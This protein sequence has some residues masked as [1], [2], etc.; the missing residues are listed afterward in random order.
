MPFLTLKSPAVTL[1]TYLTLL[2][3]AVVSPPV[4]G[5]V[6]LLKTGGRVEG[7]LLNPKQKPRTEF[8]LKLKSG[9]LLTLKAAQVAQVVSSS[10]NEKRYLELLKKMPD[11]AEGNFKMAEFCRQLEL[12][13]QRKF[14]LK[15]VV[16]LDPTHE[17]AH[18][19]LGHV[20]LEGEWGKPAE[21]MQKRGYV[22]YKNR[23]RLPQDVD[24]IKQRYNDDQAVKK[25]NRE[26]KL[27]RSWI[28]KRRDVDARKNFAS[29]ED[30]LAAPGVIE[31]LMQ[32]TDLRLQ[33]A[34]IELLGRLRTTDALKALINLALESNREETRQLCLDQ[35]VEHGRELAM[36]TFLA[37]LKSSDNLKVQRAGLGLKRVADETAIESL[38]DALVTTHKFKVSQGGG[39][40][41]I[42][43]SQG[44]GSDGRQG[45]SGFGMGGGPK[46]IQRQFQ[47]SAVLEALVNVAGVNFQ[48]DR[49]A[50]KHWLVNRSTPAV[51]DL[52][53]G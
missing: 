38:I 17:K 6:L 21:L 3:C 33:A 43:A 47:N 15:E 1:A 14:H 40:G 11:S 25:W 5:E 7:E 29:L 2:L 31:L 12:E 50:W 44:T 45:V 20:Q 49:A 34:F 13:E 26:I 28:G 22:K 10:P 35:L 37:Q 24:L 42:N 8:E 41:Q 23:W 16:L 39:P 18:R 48:F 51:V 52:R 36:Q 53:R 46:I 4:R 9:G 30:P 27:W 19:A 32:E